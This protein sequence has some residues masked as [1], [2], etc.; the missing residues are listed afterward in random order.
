MN[1]MSVEEILEFEK[2]LEELLERSENG[3]VVIVEGA[4]DR[5]CL[6]LL[7]VRGRIVEASSRPADDVAEEVC[8]LSSDVLIFTD[9]DRK[10][11]ILAE[12]LVRAFECRGVIPDVK[13][14]RRMLSLCRVKSVENMA[15]RY[16]SS[17]EA[18]RF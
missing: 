18:T 3:A 1:H 11:L 7:G 14:S 16:F 17:L 6:V 8:G 12:K 9:T 10:G 4:R 5:E 15:V 13:I 2:E